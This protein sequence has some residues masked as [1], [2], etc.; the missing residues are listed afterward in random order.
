MSTLPSTPAEAPPNRGWWWETALILLMFYLKAG[1]PPPD[2][3]EAHYLT[4]AKHFWQPDWCANDFF[5]ASPDAHAPFYFVF[6]WITLLTSLPAA[7]WIGRI[8]TWAAIAWAW[9]RLSWRIVPAPLAAVIS[10]GLMV[11][12]TTV[13]HMAGEWIIGGV[14]GKGFAFAL[15]FLGIEQTV[16]GRWNTAFILLGGGAALHVL[17]GGWA[18]AACGVAW[19]AVSGRK[20]PILQILPGLTMGFL[21][22]LFG[23]LPVLLLNRGVDA[24]TITEANYIYVYERL[25]HHLVFHQFPH[26]WMARHAALVVLFF[27]LAY[28][29]RQTASG[30]AVQ[31]LMYLVAG[32][33]G[34]AVIG[35]VIDQSTLY[36]PDVAAKL[37]RFY[38]YRLADVMVPCG[39]ALLLPAAVE[40]IRL[41]RPQLAAWGQISLL[42]LAL[43]PLLT[44]NYALQRHPL[45]GSIRQT[46]QQEDTPRPAEDT[47][48]R[49]QDWKNACAWAEANTPNDA[50]FLTPKGQQ[51]F[52]WYAAR[53]EVVSLKDI[54][55]DARGLV[56]WRR[57]M[58]DVFSYPVN[59][60]GFA[61][62]SDQ[63][64][65][66]LA[67]RYGADYVIVDT[68]VRTPGLQRVYPTADE[69][70]DSFHIYR[71]PRL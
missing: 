33:V 22:S 53:A 1:W 69:A 19:L 46:W 23:L 32:A 45:P 49:F 34:F 24:A 60:F 44:W 62:L 38:W 17:V 18:V 43:I 2:V 37:L 28:W 26:A 36:Y 50:V 54:P 35:I 12:L 67:N 4:Q 8:V 66:E 48:A 25:A 65:M 31:R 5:L 57:R 55:Q 68:F 58:H 59:R 30:A 51:T 3:N 15:V 63:Q 40:A 9:Q 70:N 39:V 16:R 20:P 6:G 41:R 42:L 47:N 56:E 52:K 14:E 64:L 11:V 13:G 7:A 27:V 61:A 21:L 10:G 71:V 29:L